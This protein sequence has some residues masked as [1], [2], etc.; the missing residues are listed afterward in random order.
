MPR[1]ATERLLAEARRQLGVWQIQLAPDRFMC[2]LC[3][4]TL[5]IS[6]A[7]TGH[8]PAATAG[9]GHYALQCADCNS[10]LGRDIERRAAEFLAT[11]R[12][13]IVVG[14]PGRGTVR[15]PV[16]LEAIDEGAGF[17]FLGKGAVHQW[18]TIRRLVGRSSRKDVLECRIT[19]PHEDTLRMAVLAWSYA[20]WTR[21]AAYGYAASP[22]AA[23][24]RSMLLEGSK[25]IPES[26]VIFFDDPLSVPLGKPAPVIV[27]QADNEVENLATDNY[28]PLG[29]GV[30]WGDRMVGVMPVA[31]DAVGEVYTSVSQ[32]MH[33]KRRIRHLDARG[34]MSAAG[35]PKLDYVLRITDRR[36][37]RT[38]FV[39][40]PL[41][42]DERAQAAGV[43][44]PRR[45]DP[46]AGPP[47]AFPKGSE[48]HFYLIED[49]DERAPI[50]RIDS[51][52][53]RKES[54]L[55]GRIVPKEICVRR[56]AG[57]SWH[58]A[59]HVRGPKANPRDFVV[60]CGADLPISGTMRRPLN[61]AG[62][63][64]SGFVCHRCSEIRGLRSVR[65][66]TAD[67][68]ISIVRASAADSRV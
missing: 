29:I 67:G 32:H 60:Y 55:M 50:P 5:P 65:Q 41:S 23:V 57:E 44:H 8:Y 40:M 53:P 47:R 63:D 33:A 49:L 27:V 68:S 18:R 4:R 48:E 17:T 7:T 36:N 54:E 56:G 62:L 28:E 42:E 1:R 15:M 58:I 39:T 31:S 24:V 14:P 59:T 9:G 38:L 22:G 3:L 20:E 10:R 2:P 19:R 46:R 52:G 6:H 45:L 30:M 13:E 34:I 11:R 25:P 43:G 26:A 37:N 51:T 16:E 61:R 21:Y 35:F 64:G 12:W 66:R